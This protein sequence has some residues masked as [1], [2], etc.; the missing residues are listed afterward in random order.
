MKPSFSIVLPVHNQADHIED[1]VGRYRSVFRGKPWEIILVPNACRDDSLLICRKLAK[2]DPKIRVVENPRGGWGLSV[3]IGLAAARGSIIGYT[4]SARTDPETIPSLLRLAQA[5][6]GALAKVSRHQRGRF[7]R[8]MGSI[9]Y[10]LECGLLFD[11]GIRDINGT[12]KIFP[13]SVY[14]KMELT[15]DGDLLDAE[16]IA[17]CRRLDVPIVEQRQEGWGRFGGKSTTGCKSALR[18]YLGALELKRRLPW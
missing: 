6:H 1:V 4:N 5:S 7:L 11:S 10:N 2:K 17:W 8:E 9:L 14:K 16:V 3:R 13:S 12:P 18:M 15:A